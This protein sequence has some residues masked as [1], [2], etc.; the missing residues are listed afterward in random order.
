MEF[1]PD[2]PI[3]QLCAQGMDMEGKGQPEEAARLFCQAWDEATSSLEK[4]TAAHYRARHQKSVQDKLK[5]D[6]TALHFALDMH[7]EQ[8]KECYPSLYLNI[9]KGYEDLNDLDRAK[10]HYQQARSFVGFLPDDGYGKMIRSGIE[11]GIKRVTSMD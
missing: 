4:F 9:G 7:D 8:V 3:I 11:S 1:D 10:E 6:E 5:W 2:N